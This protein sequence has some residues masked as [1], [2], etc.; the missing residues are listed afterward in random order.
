MFAVVAK[1]SAFRKITPVILFGGVAGQ[2][3]QAKC[4]SVTAGDMSG[5]DLNQ[6]ST[7][8]VLQTFPDWTDTPAKDLWSEHGAVIQIVRRPG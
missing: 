2:V 7:E 8:T 5:V 3:Y 4:K 1:S 6:L